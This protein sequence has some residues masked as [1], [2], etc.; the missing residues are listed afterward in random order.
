[1]CDKHIISAGHFHHSILYFILNS[2]SEKDELI[3]LHTVTFVYVI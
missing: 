2:T 3:I 1:M